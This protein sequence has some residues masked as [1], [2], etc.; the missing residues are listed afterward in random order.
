MKLYLTRNIWTTTLNKLHL[1]LTNN[2]E[3]RYVMT[4]L[5]TNGI[6]LCFCLTWNIILMVY[7]SSSVL[8]VHRMPLFP[9]VSCFVYTFFMQCLKKPQAEPIQNIWITH[10]YFVMGIKDVRHSSSI[11]VWWSTVHPNQH[12]F[13]ILLIYLYPKLHQTWKSNKQQY[14]ATTG[15]QIKKN[16]LKTTGKNHVQI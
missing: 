13:V 2:R 15:H 3:V 12:K 16:I 4:C 11:T 6:F 1:V 9:Q 14:H 5:A 7:H 10:I 8:C